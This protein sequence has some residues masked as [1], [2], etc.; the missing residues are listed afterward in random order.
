MI[1]MIKMAETKELRVDDCYR[2]DILLQ[3][4]APADMQIDGCRVEFKPCV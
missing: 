2:F 3:A 4:G 1:H